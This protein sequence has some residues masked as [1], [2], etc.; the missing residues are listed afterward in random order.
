MVPPY[1]E[2]GGGTVEKRDDGKLRIHEGLFERYKR[3][4]EVYRRDGD[5]A[6]SGKILKESKW[7]K[8]VLQID[9]FAINANENKTIRLA[10]YDRA[11]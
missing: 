8:K 3:P 9:R 7:P 10:D 2:G 1:R 5:F 6:L 4:C 11:S